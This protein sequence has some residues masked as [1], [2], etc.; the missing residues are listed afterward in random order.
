MKPLAKRTD[1]LFQ[2]DIRAVTALVNRV[3][4][5]NL[6]QGIC[7]LPTPEPIKKGAE[8]AI[9]EN[10]SIYT[11]YAGIPELRTAITEKARRFN[12][13]TVPSSNDVMVSVGSTGAFVSTMF[14]LFEPGDEA[15]LFEPFYGYHR[16]L[17]ALTG[18]VTKTIAMRGLN[19][20]VDFGEVRAVLS[21]KTKAIVINTPGNPCGKVWTRAELEEI[22]AIAEAYDLY[23]ITDEI[24]EYMTYDGNEHVSFASLPNAYERT[25]TLSGFSKTYNMTGWRLGYALAPEPLIEKM[26]LL[27]DL[28][29]ICAP[30]PLQYGLAEA[31]MMPDDY[32]THMMA[33]YTRKRK[34]MGDTLEA[35]GF[36]VPWPQGAYYILAN[37]EDLSRKVAGFSD[38]RA[39]CETL[40]K[41]AKVASVPGNSFFHHPEDGH[42]Y[43]RFCFAKE[44]PVL[45]EACENLLRAFE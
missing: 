3:N 13:I 10:R 6:G 24:Y 34:R 26:G 29:Y 33:D 7:D 23:V 30:A 20:Q 17:L 11:S 1:T 45:E 21:S 22:K 36:E 28:F 19:W 18:V 37:F 14:A 2:S 43:L 5:I 8:A 39:A 9:E 15:I 4:G 16:N 25:I 38:D 35:I 44:W 41:R 12:H 40:V 27:N 31:F 42:Y 32:F